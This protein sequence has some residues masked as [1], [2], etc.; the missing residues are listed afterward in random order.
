MEGHYRVVVVVFAREKDLVPHGVLCLDDL[1][2]FVFD[3]GDAAFVVFL[4]RHFGK[5]YRV[6]ELRDER[7]IFGDLVLLLLDR[8]KDLRGILLIRPEIRIEGLFFKLGDLCAKVIDSYRRAEILY[9]VAHTYELIFCFFKCNY[10]C[11]TSGGR[12]R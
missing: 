11:K 12:C 10:Q 1:L 6:L 4:Y 7:L 9:A 3:L 5:G 2:K 8:L